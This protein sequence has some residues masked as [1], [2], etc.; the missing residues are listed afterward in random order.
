M[1]MLPGHPKGTKDPVVVSS[2]EPEPSPLED[3]SPPRVRPA[4]E[5]SPS[6]AGVKDGAD[7]K[8]EALFRSLAR[9]TLRSLEPTIE[10]FVQEEVWLFGYGADG[11]P[12][13]AERLAQGGF[14]QAQIAPLTI[15]GRAYAMGASGVVLLHYR[16][17]LAV[18]HLPVELPPLAHLVLGCELFGV[19]L[20]DHIVLDETGKATF[21]R[22]SGVFKEI[23]SRASA[24]QQEL[25]ALD[26]AKPWPLP[27]RQGSHLS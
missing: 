7:E 11:R 25:K 20:I 12:R 6:A 10:E 8:R 13:G 19:A 4:G 21:L 22:E 18:P 26:Q 17:D 9:D 23:A 27:S 5:A 14:E 24:I 1:S 3:A 2:V 15:I 16:P